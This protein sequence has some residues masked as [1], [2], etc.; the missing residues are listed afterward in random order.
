MLLCDGCNDAYHGY[1]L[2]PK[3]DVL[4][5]VLWFCSKCALTGLYPLTGTARGELAP[6]KKAA[7]R[8]S[9]RLDQGT[10][11]GPD[12]RPIEDL[13]PANLDPTDPVEVFPVPAE[14]T[15]RMLTT[16]RELTGRPTEIDVPMDGEILSDSLFHV[17]ESSPLI[18]GD[19]Q[20][21]V[22]IPVIS[23]QASRV[24][25]FERQHGCLVL[26]QKQSRGGLNEPRL[27]RV[28]FLGMHCMPRPYR[29]TYR[30]GSQERLNYAMVSDT[31]LL[32]S[33]VTDVMGEIP[34]MSG[35][36]VV[37]SSP[38]RAAAAS[39]VRQ[40]RPSV[41]ADLPASWVLTSEKSMRIALEHLMP[42]DWAPK[43]IT[44]L[45]QQCRGGTSLTQQLEPRYGASY[46]SEREVL[47]GAVD[48][49]MVV[50]ILDPCSGDG[51][52]V[53]ALREAGLSVI[54]NESNAHMPAEHHFNVLQPQSWRSMQRLFGVHAVVMTPLFTLVDLVLPLA[55]AF[56]DQLVACHVQWT[57]LSEAHGARMTWLRLLQDQGR[58]HFILGPPRGATVKRCLWVLVFASPALKARILTAPQE[59]FCSLRLT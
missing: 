48:F 16:L 32:E 38:R 8:R 26:R 42:G 21:P 27:G 3:I 35:P 43:L 46:L 11:P 37:R 53:T 58:L 31:L 59:T 13:L 17:S 2:S 45:S 20:L 22:A 54:S 1:C 29:C 15:P 7:V 4:P 5:E 44:G 49:S 51:S 34:P 33:D 10:I 36:V 50:S 19:R 47:L 39:S 28:E 30:D 57:Y 55:V 12:P 9:R 24:Q 56:A 52:L 18:I 25:D 14:V 40:Y 6:P 23:K 41:S